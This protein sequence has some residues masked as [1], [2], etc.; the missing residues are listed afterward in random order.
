MEYCSGGSLFDFLLKHGRL[1][2]IQ[3]SYWFKIIYY[4]IEALRDASI[5]H[6][7]LKPEN[8]LLDKDDF[9]ANLKITD[10]GLS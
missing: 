7:D 1:E 6:R 5:I 8:I 3:A 4:G 10:F 2:E 9:S